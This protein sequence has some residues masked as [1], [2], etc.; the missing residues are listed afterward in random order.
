MARL[1][2]LNTKLGTLSMALYYRGNRNGLLGGR[3]KDE[4]TSRKMNFTVLGNGWPDSKW[5]ASSAWVYLLVGSMDLK[6]ELTFCAIQVQT[7]RVRR[8]KELRVQGVV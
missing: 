5:I 8:L 6:L 3:G 1:N 2:A 4:A 7:Q